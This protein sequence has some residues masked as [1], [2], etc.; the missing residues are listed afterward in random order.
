MKNIV[1]LI[2][3]ILLVGAFGVQ[4]VTTTVGMYDFEGTAGNVISS[5]GA[6]SAAGS[7]TVTY[8]SQTAP[9]SGGS[10]S[11]NFDGAGYLLSAAGDMPTVAN[12]NVGVEAWVRFEQIDNFDF[13]YNIG[14][15]AGANTGDINAGHGSLWDTGAGS[16]IGLN[17]WVGAAVPNPVIV[18]EIQ[19]WY[20]IAFVMDGGKSDLY[21]DG[22]LAASTASLP[23]IAADGHF[24]VGGHQFDAAAGN[25][26]LN[27][28]IDDLHIFTFD[29]GAFNAATDLIVPEPFMLVL[30]GVGGLAALRR[31][32]YE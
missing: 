6:L 27:G 7:G 26:I 11:A 31:R 5:T 13:V 3:I 17:S 23:F 24:A 8:S 30:M 4:A 22:S 25:G 20:H 18:P 16:I 1:Y 21:I 12:D 19:Q 10:T 2:I 28:Q 32:K 29:T 14:G 15:K 9:G